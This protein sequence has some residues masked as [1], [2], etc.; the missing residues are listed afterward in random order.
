V[1]FLKLIQQLV[2]ALNSDGTPG[3]VAAGIALGA[4][5]G[6]TPLLNL[7]NLVLFGCALILN[8]SMPGVFLGWALCVPVGFAL[9]PLFDA[10]GSRL[11]L[12]PGLRGLWT[13]LYNAPVVPFTNFNNTVVLG[14]FVVWVV[15]F[16][17]IF[18]LARWGVA[19]Y[20]ATLLERL[21]RMRV[22]QAI[23]ASGWYTTYKSLTGWKL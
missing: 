11:L 1:L 22:F 16:L 21:R 12:A 20:R 4:V 10:V 2:K 17:P 5:F 6:L 14:S 3:Q 19:R 7:H 18:F 15:A 9:D 8:V 23:T 13:A